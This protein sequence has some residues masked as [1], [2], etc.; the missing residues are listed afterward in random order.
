[1]DAV[2]TVDHEL[3]PLYRGSSLTRESE[4]SSRINIDM[5]ARI[6]GKPHQ[7]VMRIVTDIVSKNVER[8]YV[9]DRWTYVYNVDLH[10]LDRQLDVDRARRCSS[11]I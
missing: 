11:Y 2:L 10:I 7:Q 4:S 8:M 9:N 1:M 3:K 5:Q 6:V